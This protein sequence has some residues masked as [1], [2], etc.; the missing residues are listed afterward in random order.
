M[1]KLTYSS[2]I[3]DAVGVG[4]EIIKSSY[5][6]KKQASTIFDCD[7]ESM[8]PPKGKTGIHLTALG[9]METYGFNRNADGFKNVDCRN[10]CDTFV[11]HGHVYQHHRNK[12]PKKALGEIKK[13]AYN[14]DWADNEKAH[15]RHK[16][17]VNSRV[18]R[19]SKCNSE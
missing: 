7:Y 8:K 18:N 3:S 14:P 17:W 10:R 6:L 19:Q 5:D 13:A 2:D 15:G 12:D 11:K 16:K 1:I 9:D 4:G